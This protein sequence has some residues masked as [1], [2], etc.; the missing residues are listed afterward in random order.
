MNRAKL[1]KMDVRIQKIRKAA[2]EL[3]ELS[4]GIQAVDRNASRILASVKML[5]I[6]ISDLLEINP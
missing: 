5:E 6:N 3:K 2:Q 1:K 4:G